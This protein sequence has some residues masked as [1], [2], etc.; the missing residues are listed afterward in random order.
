[1]FNVIAN[2]VV[3]II[4]DLALDRVIAERFIREFR[5]T[6]QSAIIQGHLLIYHSL[7]I[8]QQKSSKSDVPIIDCHNQKDPEFP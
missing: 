3:F 2:V 7:N 5:A 4:N 1:M 6:M 8:N